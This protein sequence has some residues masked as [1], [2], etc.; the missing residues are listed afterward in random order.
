MTSNQILNSFLTKTKTIHPSVKNNVQSNF[1]GLS[2]FKIKKIQ[3]VNTFSKNDIK[4]G[5]RKIIQEGASKI[6]YSF[7]KEM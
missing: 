5:I 1:N 2:V 3:F 4:S 6:A 7:L